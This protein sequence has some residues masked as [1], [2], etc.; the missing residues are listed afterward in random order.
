MDPRI[1]SY[2]ALCL[3]CLLVK[4]N[5]AM[6][7]T[8]FLR[9]Q[10]PSSKLFTIESFSVVK[11][12]GEGYESAVFDAAGYKW[13]LVMFPVG[14]QDDGGSNYVSMYLRIE[15]TESLPKSWEINVDLKLFVHNQKL[16]KYLT[17]QDGTTKR[18]NEAKKEWGFAQ[19][20]PL[21]TLNNPN[22]GYVSGDRVTFGAEIFLLNKIQEI[23]KVTFV[24]SPANNKF[25][26]TISYF[27]QLEDKFYFS[28]A[29]LV[30]D[31]YWRLGLNPKGL[32]GGRGTAL[33]VL[34]FTYE[35]SQNAPATT[36]WG[37][38]YLRLRNQRYSNYVE[39]YSAAWYP[40]RNGYG[41]GVH[42]IISFQDLYDKSKG[43]LVNDRIVLEAEMPMVSVS[44]IVPN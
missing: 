2:G 42:N 20:I 44:N 16:N 39:K 35:F 30:G 41:V 31:R 40:V 38:V 11:S 15:E 10:P 24:Q 23:E 36:T 18:F 19:M 21:S 33:P 27:P 32:G 28:D 7:V 3:V 34:L 37:A 14:K 9:D 1:S 5:M 26:W 4:L 13:R 43:Y 8:S 25:S 17:V 29:F 6:G 22:E 12:R